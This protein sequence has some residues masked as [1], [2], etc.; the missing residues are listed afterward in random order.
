MND[1]LSRPAT[2]EVAERQRR[3]T[4]YQREMSGCR[5]CVAAGHLECAFPIFHGN[6]SCRVMV[7][8]QAPAAPSFERRLPYSGAT[9][10]TLQRWLD[11]AGFPSGFLHQRCYLTSLTKCFPGTQQTGK[12]DR[13]PSSAEISLCS[14]HLDQ[15]L[16]LVQPELILPLGRLA[17]TRFAGRAPLTVLVGTLHR[18]NRSAVLPLPH[19]SGVSH[20]LNEPEHQALLAQ[21]LDHLGRLRM[22]LSLD[23]PSSETVSDG[24]RSVKA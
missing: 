14:A 11:Q 19:P 7:V 8:G 22:E 1:A 4:R 10:R 3:L 21:A 18:F 6:A 16:A 13:A 15:E 23:L 12:G 17:I 20:W 9:G 5:R 2:V 24:A